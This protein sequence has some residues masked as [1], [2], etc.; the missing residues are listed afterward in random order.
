MAV[1]QLITDTL[2]QSDTLLLDSRAM[3]HAVVPQPT[4]TLPAGAQC[5]TL[6]VDTLSTGALNET[7]SVDTLPLVPSADSWVITLFIL[8][9]LFFSF[10]FRNS[11]KYLNNIFI[12]LFKVN[13][14][15]NPFAETTI[16]ENQLKISLFALTFYTEGI[17]LYHLFIAPILTNS[18]MILPCIVGCSLISWLYY[19]LQKGIYSLLGNIFSTAQ[20]TLFFKESFSSVNLIIGLFFMPLATLLLFVDGAVGTV[21]IISLI[22]YFLSRLIIIFKGIRIF[23]PDIF[24]LLYIILYLCALEILPLLYIKYAVVEMY[25]LFELNIIIS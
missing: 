16:N 12:S 3:T 18:N 14:H 8:I 19:L 23:S 2:Q 17:L 20:Q 21:V 4:D 25:K 24:G 22:I 7:L 1:N 11:Y 13:Y 15:E 5:E 6:S 10:S 9:F